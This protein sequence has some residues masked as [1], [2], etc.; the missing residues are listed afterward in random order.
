M[1]VDGTVC[2]PQAASGKQA[3]RMDGEESSTALSEGS[4]EAAAACGEVC[5][6]VE[7]A[8]QAPRMKWYS[9]APTGVQ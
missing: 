5:P 8:T 6:V 2:A 9:V 4:A 1:D 7:E 3:G